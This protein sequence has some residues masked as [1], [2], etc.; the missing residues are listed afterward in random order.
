M[1]YRRTKAEHPYEPSLCGVRLVPVLALSTVEF[2]YDPDR[3]PIVQ[4]LSFQVNP[5]NFLVILGA[6]GSGKSTIIRLC[7]GL[8]KPN[9]GV[10][11]VR[12]ETPE[13][14][15]IATVVF[16]EY[17]R[18]LLPWRTS[19]GNVRL[20]LEHLSG[21]PEANHDHSMAALELVG[22]SKWA[23]AYPRQLS[24]GMRQRLSLARA[25]VMDPDVLLLDEPFGSLDANTREDL[26]VRLNRIWSQRQI[27]TVMSTHDIDEAILLGTHLALLSS[28]ERNIVELF[29]NPV[30]RSVPIEQVR[31]SPDY[32]RVWQHI[33][34]FLFHGTTG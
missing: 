9:R 18:T 11:E 8:L 2:S 24:G 25:L 19:L 13:K 28:Q 4:D 5:G 15:A 14:K 1:D 32:I 31:A 3:R 22:L 34:R 29:P 12:T 27:A 7:A 20:A 33:R 6:S 30:D 17:E 26:R 23:T 16:Q 21:T 10:V